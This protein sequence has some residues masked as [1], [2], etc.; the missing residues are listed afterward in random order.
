L[1]GAGGMGEVWAARNELTNRDFAIKF[2]LA[3]FAHHGEAYERFVREAETTGRLKHP[4]IVDVFDIAQTPEGYPFIVMELLMGEDL[5]TRLAREKTLS[6]LSTAAYFAQLATGLDLAHQAGVIH[7]DLSP[8]NIFL[9]QCPEGGEPIPKILDFGVSK[10]IG[11]G[12]AREMKT[13]DGAVLG[14]P[15]FMSPEQA[16]GAE[17]VDR[18]TDVWSL[19]ATMY[20][21]LAGAPPFRAGNYNALMFSITSLKH[22]ALSKLAPGADEQ[23]VEVI[24]AC[25]VKDRE[26]RLG[27]AALLAAELSGIARRLAADANQLMRTPQRRATDRLPP[28][29]NSSTDGYISSFGRKRRGRFT[30]AGAERPISPWLIA[31]VA[32]SVGLAVGVG[33]ARFSWSTAPSDGGVPPANPEIARATG[34][35]ASAR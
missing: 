33:V 12:A 11:P 8:A 25:L 26:Q 7:R 35:A 27:S 29:A 18:R 1:I 30:A 32:A 15:M 16:R 3:E 20:Q 21:C 9:A 22:V 31:T 13:C 6:S 4:S 24:E 17:R 23:L 28:A 19:G 2:L 10:T 5:A 34:A 14:N